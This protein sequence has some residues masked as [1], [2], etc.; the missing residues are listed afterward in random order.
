MCPYTSIIATDRN[1]K[2]FSHEIKKKRT[3]NE[4]DNSAILFAMI[5]FYYCV[6]VQ[7]RFRCIYIY[8]YLQKLFKRN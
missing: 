3:E 7:K 5:I 4:D 6:F 8:I 1:V 2:D